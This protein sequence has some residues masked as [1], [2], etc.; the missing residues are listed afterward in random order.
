MTLDEFAS[1]AAAQT[2]WYQCW[3]RYAV[4][5]SPADADVLRRLASG[6]LAADPPAFRLLVRSEQPERACPTSPALLGRLMQL[7]TQI[8]RLT[9]RRARLQQRLSRLVLSEGQAAVVSSPAVRPRRGRPLKAN[10]QAQ[11]I[12]AVLAAA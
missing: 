12:A 7:D 2:P 10:S 8:A 9:W 6:G 1:H 4:T 3:Q 11:Q 5:H